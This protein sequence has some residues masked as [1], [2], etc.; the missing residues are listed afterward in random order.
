MAPV[1]ANGPKSGRLSKNIDPNNPQNQQ[2]IKVSIYKK[3]NMLIVL[4]FPS[5]SLRIGK[6]TFETT[7]TFDMD[8]DKTK[9]NIPNKEAMKTQSKIILITVNGCLYLYEMNPITVKA[10]KIS[11]I[12]DN[13]D[14]QLK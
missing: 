11:N 8:C 9:H 3:L 7:I 14:A 13:I 1:D 6:K 4:I 10:H 5:T 2:E 12:N